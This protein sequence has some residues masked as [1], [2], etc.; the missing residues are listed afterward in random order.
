MAGPEWISQLSAGVFDLNIIGQ[1]G[2]ANR[3]SFKFDAFLEATPDWGDPEPRKKH[4]YDVSPFIERNELGVKL[5]QFSIN[6]FLTDWTGKKLEHIVKE[7]LLHDGIRHMLCFVSIPVPIDYCCQG[8]IELVQASQNRPKKCFPMI[9]V[10]TAG[11]AEASDAYNSLIKRRKW[12]KI[13]D[14][15][16]PWNAPPLR[17]LQDK[18]EKRPKL[19]IVVG[20]AKDVLKFV[21]DTNDELEM[22]DLRLSVR[23]IV[24]SGV[25]NMPVEPI[26]MDTCA[27]IA[28]Y[29]AHSPTTYLFLFDF[30]DAPSTLLEGK[31]ACESIIG[32]G[33][34]LFVEVEQINLLKIFKEIKLLLV[35]P[36]EEFVNRMA[37]EKLE[38]GVEMDEKTFELAKLLMTPKAQKLQLC[39]NTI[40]NLRNMRLGENQRYHSE[41]KERILVVTKNKMQCIFV[42]TYLRNRQNVGEP[43]SSY[44]VDKIIEGDTNEVAEMKNYE[45]RY[46]QVEVLVIDWRSIQ[47]VHRGTVDSVIFYD[48]PER[49]YFQ[50]MMEIELENLTSRAAV[51]IKVYILFDEKA[52]LQYLGQYYKLLDKFHK[53]LPQWFPVL[54]EKF[55]ADCEETAAES[56][57]NPLTTVFRHSAAA[58]SPQCRRCFARTPPEQEMASE[59]KA[60]MYG[61]LVPNSAERCEENAENVFEIAPKVDILVR[62]ITNSTG[63]ILVLFGNAKTC[64]LV[65]LEVQTSGIETKILTNDMLDDV[66]V[67]KLKT[68][69]MNASGAGRFAMLTNIH[70]FE[71]IQLPLFKQYIIFDLPDKVVWFPKTLKSIEKLARAEQCTVRIDTIITKMTPLINIKAQLVEMSKRGCSLPES[72]I[73][74][75]SCKQRQHDQ[76]K[77]KEIDAS[78][79]TKEKKS[80]DVVPLKQPVKTSKATVKQIDASLAE[81]AIKET[82]AIHVPIVH[83]SPSSVPSS[84]TNSSSTPS[85]SNSSDSTTAPSRKAPEPVKQ[86]NSSDSY[87]LKPLG[88][89]MFL[90]P[91]PMYACDSDEEEERWAAMEAEES[92]KEDAGQMD[93][94]YAYDSSEEYM[95][96]Y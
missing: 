5:A 77:E 40:S 14:L 33:D 42:M 60:T 83:P 34:N 37:A 87:Y 89:G 30:V 71:K 93:D 25:E 56:E 46:G 6:S 41:R 44:L 11:R 80:E 24:I 12:C 96:E 88:N 43:T 57:S 72:L 67:E 29:F 62:L 55:R 78:T 74:L 76:L 1:T 7:Y 79:E 59:R 10:V 75:M 22:A 31:K 85:S 84:S 70:A 81:L 73:Q 61:H 91:K 50:T 21:K 90:I 65:S 15:G 19:D 38:N 45:F 51:Q 69:I 48:P 32:G 17:R 66:D 28:R 47:S 82:N 94:S 53:D 20:S 3:G 36:T 26:F 68:Q 92:A 18:H 54:Y 13:R 35:V 63:P 52:D 9:I 39:V 95:F 8:L 4:K 86:N 16:R 2:E 58:A 49:Q 27:A 64:R 23:H